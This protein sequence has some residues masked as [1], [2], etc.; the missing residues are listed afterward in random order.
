MAAH[1]KRFIKRKLF[2]W[3]MDSHLITFYL[4]KKFYCK[5]LVPSLFDAKMKKVAAAGLKQE[6][7]MHSH[8]NLLTNFVEQ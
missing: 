5:Y 2:L 3:T 1:G 7:G 6:K 8:G 4:R